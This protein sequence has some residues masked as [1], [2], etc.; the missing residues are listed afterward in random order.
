MTF[1]DRLRDA[2]ACQTCRR[3]RH[4]VLLVLGALALTWLLG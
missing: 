4:G 2:W 3:Y 1:A